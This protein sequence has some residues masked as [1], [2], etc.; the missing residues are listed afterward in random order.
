MTVNQYIL[1][2]HLPQFLLL[3]YIIIILIDTHGGAKGGSL[4]S[5]LQIIVSRGSKRAWN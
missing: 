2:T 1:N 4:E 5:V 3:F